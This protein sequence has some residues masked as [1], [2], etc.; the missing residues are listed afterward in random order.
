MPPEYYFGIFIGLMLI[1]LLVL[2]FKP[3][4][5]ARRAVRRN[6]ND[7]DKDQLVHQLS[8]IADSLEKLV[9]HLEAAHVEASPLAEKAAVLPQKALERSDTEEKKIEQ[10]SAS[11][12]RVNEPQVEQPSASEPQVKERHVSLSMFGR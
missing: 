12:P 4:P 10:P 7:N 2:L 5:G 6:S 9:G 1:V 8:R 11:E 3:R